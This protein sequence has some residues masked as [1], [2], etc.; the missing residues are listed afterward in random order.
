MSG[1]AWFVAELQKRG[2]TA[3]LSELGD[4]L[5][6]EDPTRFAQLQA[7]LGG[8]RRW[9]QGLVESG[10]VEVSGDPAHRAVTLAALQV[11]PDAAAARLH[12]LRVMQQPEIMCPLCQVPVCRGDW[13]THQRGRK[14]R[15]KAEGL[16]TASNSPSD[17][18]S[19]EDR[20]APRRPRFAAGAAPAIGWG[21]DEPPPLVHESPGPAPAIA[22][23]VPAIHPDHTDALYVA[24]LRAPAPPAA[25]QGPAAA[26]EPAPSWH[27]PQSPWQ[28]NAV[29]VPPRA[30]PQGVQAAP[31]TAPAAA[32]P[33]APA[34]AP[35]APQTHET[36]ARPPLR[37][38]PNSAPLPP[39]KA[40]TPLPPPQE[41]RY[42]SASPLPP[43]PSAV[44]SS[45][46]V[47]PAGTAADAALA[48][49]APPATP[50]LEPDP[51]AATGFWCSMRFLLPLVMCITSLAM[52]T[53]I[54]WLMLYNTKAAVD[55]MMSQVE[56]QL[57]HG[58]ITFVESQLLRM[59]EINN[60]TADYFS[61]HPDLAEPPGGVGMLLPRYGAVV[62]DMMRR[63][64]GAAIVSNHFFFHT[65]GRVM[66]IVTDWSKTA[67]E[68]AAGSGDL[69]WYVEEE[70]GVGCNHFRVPR[71]D[72]VGAFRFDQDFEM[73][74]QRTGA[75]EGPVMLFG[76]KLLDRSDATTYMEG[77]FVYNHSGQLEVADS[78]T[79]HW[80]APGR[81][82]VPAG[83]TEAGR[84]LFTLR[85]NA[86]EYQVMTDYRGAERPYFKNVDHSV[87]YD[88]AWYGP[89][90]VRS[91]MLYAVTQTVRNNGRFVGVIG[92]DAFVDGFRERLMDL[93]EKARLPGDAEIFIITR[94]GDGLFSAS[95]GEV[96]MCEESLL[97]H[98]CDSGDSG[99]VCRSGR[100]PAIGSCRPRPAHLSTNPI[101]AEAGRDLSQGSFQLNGRT[102]RLATM[103]YNE[104]R[105]SLVAAVVIPEEP[106]VE[107]AN[108][109]TVRTLLVATMVAFVGVLVIVKICDFFAAALRELASDLDRFSRLDFAHRRDNPRGW[110]L[111]ELAQARAACLR[112]RRAVEMFSLYVPTGERERLPEGLRIRDELLPRPWVA[113]GEGSFGR[114]YRAHFLRT[115]SDVAVKELHPRREGESA[116]DALTRRGRFLEEMRN[117]ERLRI[118]YIVMFY[119]WT[120]G[121]GGAVCM[122]TEYCHGGSLRQRIAATDLAPE[123]RGIIALH[124]GRAVARA[125]LY[126]HTRGEVH[127]D[128]AARNVLITAADEYK[129]A[130]LGNLCMVG[131]PAATVSVAWSPPESLAGSASGCTAHPAHDVW[132]YGCMLYEVLSGSWPWAHLLPEGSGPYPP[133]GLGCTLAG[134]TAA[135]RDT[136]ARWL[137]LAR[138]AICGG[139]GHPAPEYCRPS[140]GGLCAALWQQVVSKCWRRDRSRR[141]SMGQL[142]TL[143]DATAADFDVATSSRLT[144]DD[145]GTSA[146]SQAVPSSSLP[147]GRTSPP[148]QP[149]SLAAF[150]GPAVVSHREGTGE[151]P[152]VGRRYSGSDAHSGDAWE[153]GGRP[154]REGWAATA[155][156]LQ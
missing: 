61:R 115:M 2:G 78:E 21:A 31:M 91:W 81:R 8:R 40:P 93:K 133:V 137:S 95:S 59:L 99:E 47:T 75:L 55:E 89:F 106:Y 82:L 148:R 53:V 127:M 140:A 154:F 121:A 50:Q 17:G 114:V 28:Q 45:D 29:A 12:G 39:P 9:T 113:V 20:G 105:L 149:V 87:P 71:T 74:D 14:H 25:S 96:V 70:L 111:S 136:A 143:L 128:V 85:Y 101:I 49:A 10:I 67:E 109:G 16:A 33:E 4:A 13:D 69:Y 156:Q 144:D 84:W 7:E 30:P 23:P 135:E 3:R 80:L 92:T 18:S 150:T 27:R 83:S 37:E 46:P 102:Y 32:Q 98:S 129:L 90:N 103:P 104:N 131:G 68:R 153:G 88:W 5:R 139:S 72:E 66:G 64:T 110:R 73:T 38:A 42:D 54:T 130:D 6:R 120:R 152:Q 1:L 124:S 94:T 116:A 65:N 97:H 77:H 34:A 57:L 44:H 138:G 125:L 19:K 22:A 43:P 134:R 108:R 35:A 76:G 146:Q 117:L 56:A 26:L 86:T 142:I 58:T 126:L 41:G 60:A 24:P 112:V 100:A 36:E 62:A 151:A 48:G 52:I 123:R 15:R 118:N 79:G 132:A 63:V 119:G 145:G 147:S 107:R 11:P 141:P 51:P 122:V 155:P